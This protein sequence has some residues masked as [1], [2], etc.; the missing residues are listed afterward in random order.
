[1]LS[2]CCSVSLLVLDTEDEKDASTIT[3][4]SDKSG[5][6]IKR[7][8]VGGLFNSESRRYQLPTRMETPFDDDHA[9]CRPGR[10]DTSHYCH[11]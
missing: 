5:N 11:C 8:K 4:R 6:K 3:I 7:D 2:L 1:M 9:S 10:L